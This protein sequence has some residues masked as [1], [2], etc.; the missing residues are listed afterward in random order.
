MLKCQF[1]PNVSTDSMQFQQTCFYKLVVAD[2][3]I[4]MQI[5]RGWKR[6][7]TIKKRI[8]LENLYY[9]ISRFTSRP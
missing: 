8:M 1:S 3:K 4:D 5:Q 6:Q 7:N 9:Q 2:V